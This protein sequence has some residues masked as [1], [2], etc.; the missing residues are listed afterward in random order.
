MSTY[1]IEVLSNADFVKVF[2]GPW[3]RQQIGHLTLEWAQ[4]EHNRSV[5]E[6]RPWMSEENLD[7]FNNRTWKERP[8]IRKP[9]EDEMADYREQENEL[10]YERERQRRES[11]ESSRR[12][13]DPY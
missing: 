1:G 11:I 6:P 4:Q 9:S 13:R 5:W 10:R 7:R 12:W 3:L 8:K 2:C